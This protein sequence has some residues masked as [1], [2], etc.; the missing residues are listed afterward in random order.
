MNH[1]F[2]NNPWS[3]INSLLASIIAT[4]SASVVNKATIFCICI[5]ITFY[6]QFSF[7]KVQTLLCRAPQ[8]P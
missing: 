6:F 7:A 3:H 1:N 5:Y 2:V 4:Y 8:V